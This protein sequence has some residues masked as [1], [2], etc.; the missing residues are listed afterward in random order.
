ML[1]FLRLSL[2]HVR[3]QG[4]AGASDGWWRAFSPLRGEKVAEG[5][6]GRMRGAGCC[7]RSEE[8][9]LTPTLSP[10]MKPKQHD[11]VHCGGEGGTTNHQMHPGMAAG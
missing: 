5:A 6:E 7:Q 1:E 2:R 11:A 9:P 10:A 3:K 8:F 4:M